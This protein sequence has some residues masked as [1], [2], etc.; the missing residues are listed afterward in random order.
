[1]TVS[2]R[3]R[4]NTVLPP[5]DQRY[6]TAVLPA[7]VRPRRQT[8]YVGELGLRFVIDTNLIDNETSPM[9]KLWDLHRSHMIELLRTDVMDTELARTEDPEK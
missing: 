1:M 5:S 8:A 3:L 2:L 4:S 7:I 6:R 9:N